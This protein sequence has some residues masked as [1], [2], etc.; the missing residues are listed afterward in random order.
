MKVKEKKEIRLERVVTK[1]GVE[2]WKIVVSPGHFF[3]E[4]NPQK[5]TKYGVAYKQLKEIYPDFFMFWEIKGNHY[6]GRLLTG[7]FLSKEEIDKFI[8]S[9]L[10]N[11]DYKEYE[12]VKDEII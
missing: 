4:Q 9:V 11:E 8:T 7:S 5:E 2:L 12:D 1:K 10:Q 3:L 6:T